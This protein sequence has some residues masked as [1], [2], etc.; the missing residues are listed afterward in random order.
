MTDRKVHDM[1]K[2]KTEIARQKKSENSLAGKWGN[3]YTQENNR[4]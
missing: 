4:I 1:E 2:G 3:I